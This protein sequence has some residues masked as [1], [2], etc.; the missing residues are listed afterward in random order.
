MKTISIST[1]KQCELIDITQNVAR[2]VAESGM[3]SGLVCIFIPHTTAGITINENAD[4]DVK[5]DLLYA[6]ERAVPNS[7]FLHAEENSDA[8][9]KALMTGFSVSVIVENA[10]LM[11]GTWQSIYFCEFDGPRS[12]KAYVKILKTVD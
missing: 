12:R 3:Q 1:A 8:H 10:R 7:G 11:L 9:T 2:I 5:R 4:P 6:L